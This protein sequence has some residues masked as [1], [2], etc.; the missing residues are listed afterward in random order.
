MYR[1]MLT[2]A[3]AADPTTRFASYDRSQQS[4]QVVE[5]PA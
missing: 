2:M 1:M 4:V 5:V 3:Q